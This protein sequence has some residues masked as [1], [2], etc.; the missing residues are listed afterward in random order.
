MTRDELIDELAAVMAEHITAARSH[1]YAVDVAVAARA[2]LTALE[3]AGVRLVPV[4]ATMEMTHAVWATDM[5]TPDMHGD[6]ADLD[7]QLAARNIYRAMLAASPYAPT[8][9]EQTHKM[10]ELEKLRQIWLTSEDEDDA[11]AFA[12]ACGNALPEMLAKVKRL[13]EALKPF[14]AVGGRVSADTNDERHIWP[15]GGITAGDFRRARAAL[16]ETP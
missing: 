11:F 9:K 12:D 14:A 10:N 8:Q 15:I 5:Q 1:G 16:K 4:E 2:Q 6:Y 13:E 7:I 3:A